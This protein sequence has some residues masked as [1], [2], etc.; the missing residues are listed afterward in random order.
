[1]GQHLPPVLA[2]TR[3][4]GHP[5]GP[6][7]GLKD[8]LDPTQGIDSSVAGPRLSTSYFAL[9][10]IPSVLVEMH[11]YKPFAQRVR[12]NRD[13]LEALLGEVG[14]HADS[15]V[16]A[17]SAARGRTVALGRPDADP[18]SV[19]LRWQLDDGTRSTVLFPAFDWSTGESV[20]FGGPGLRFHRGQSRE[21]EVPW[22]HRLRPELE[23]ARPRGY[24]VLP[25]WPQIEEKLLAH[26]LQLSRLSRSDEL[27]V[28]TIRIAEPRFEDSAYQG[29]VRLEVQVA[30]QRE[31]RSVPAGAIWIPADQPDFEVAVQLLEPEAPD[32]LVRWGFLSA[33]LESR[34]YVSPSV[35]DGLARQMLA[36]AEIRAEW[37]E[38]LRDADLAANPRRRYLWWYR[39]TPF[40]DEEVGLLPA[41]R[42]MDRPS[43]AVDAWSGA[44]LP[45]RSG[46]E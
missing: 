21:L 14:R 10:N 42:V 43:F 31:R 4:A 12:A 34:E 25:G 45:V 15:L 38:A 29:R 36:D 20:V 35:L 16:E 17:V 26:G 28:E 19:V 37:E 7:V 30:R 22:F 44:A 2:A 9:R 33:V 27:D 8:A 18:S 5:C 1:M 3:A 46:R 32:S 23:V 13:F 39:R 41:L 6:Y 11:A 40:W 24:L